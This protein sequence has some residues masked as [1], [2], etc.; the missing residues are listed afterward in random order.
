MIYLIS[1]QNSVK[2]QTIPNKNKNSN[3]KEFKTMK[4]LF[5]NM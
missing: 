5:K 3:S 4:W 1:E 2:F